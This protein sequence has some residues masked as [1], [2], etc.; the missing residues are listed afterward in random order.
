MTFNTF[1]KFLFSYKC[2]SSSNSQPH[3]KHQFRFEVVHLKHAGPSRLKNKN[4]CVSPA[5]T[6]A[7]TSIQKLEASQASTSINRSIMKQKEDA[8]QSVP[9]DKRQRNTTK[10]VHNRSATGR[11]AEVLTQNNQKQNGASQREHIILKPKV[12]YLHEQKVTSTNGKE[13]KTLK[14]NY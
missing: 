4:K 9:L 7:R 1:D 12:P 13:V 3:G 2:A 6:R 14:K 8:G 11:T 10:R 5:T